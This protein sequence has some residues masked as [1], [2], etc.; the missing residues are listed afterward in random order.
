MQVGH[1]QQS[2]PAYYD[3]NP[4]NVQLDYSAAGVAPH[5]STQRWTNTIASGKKGFIE[6]LYALAYK[7][8]TGGVNGLSQASIYYT[9]S[10]GAQ[11]ILLGAQIFGT[12]AGAQ[13]VMSTTSAG[14]LQAGDVLAGFT[15]D[16]ATGGTMNFFL[17]A[18]VML[19]DA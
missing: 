19:Y 1:I 15:N 4:S 10:G 12:A 13:H 17:T 7:A 8:T 5:A 14:V 3:R 16:L 9:P 2:R 18:K 6:N 11:G